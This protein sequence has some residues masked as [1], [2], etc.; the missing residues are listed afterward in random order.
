[1]FGIMLELG[2]REAAAYL[3]D[4]SSAVTSSA[5]FW[6]PPKHLFLLC[7]SSRPASSLNPYL[8]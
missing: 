4:K 2:L 8:S 7:Q 3:R 1:L 6:L 5:S